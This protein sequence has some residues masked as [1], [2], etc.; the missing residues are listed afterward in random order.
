MRHQRRGRKL[1]RDSAHRKALMMNLAGELIEHGRIR[2]TVAKAKELRP[3][4]ERL[5][6]RAGKGTLH[7][8]RVIETRLR[9]HDKAAKRQ[10]ST[11][12]QRQHTIV[13][14]LMNDIAPRFKDRPGGYTRIL[15]LGPRPGDNAEMALIEW[16]DFEPEA[17]GNA[18]SAAAL[19]EQL[20]AANA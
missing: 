2:T 3:Y 12:E 18:P 8:R 5:V 6:T 17:A 15:K 7:D 14:K 16:V 10:A 11:L 13:D 9:M 4:V 1:G 20:E 19:A